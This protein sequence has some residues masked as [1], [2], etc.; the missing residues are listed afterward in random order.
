LININL[1][2]CNGCGAC[3]EICPEG[4]LYLVD[5]KAAVDTR[6]CRECEAC[7]AACPTEAI[8]ITSPA[9]SP[10]PQR[11]LTPAPRPEPAV[12]R[13]EREMAPAP[14]RTKVLPVV[15]AALTWAG[16]ELVPRLATY[17]LDSLDRRMATRPT[18]DIA[19]SGSSSTNRGGGGR[20][21]RHRHRGGRGNAG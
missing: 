20:Q 19:R 8:T 17:L 14:A 7:V 9:A 10:E 3:V 4:A 1:E 21:R 5:N 13:I 2:R 18:S 16:R 11:V 15:G 6:L 12:V